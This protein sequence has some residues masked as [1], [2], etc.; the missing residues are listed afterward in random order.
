[1]NTPR[2]D[3]EIAQTVSSNQPSVCLFARYSA[4][5]A[6]TKS[7]AMYPAAEAAEDI[8][9]FSKMENSRRAREGNVRRSVENKAYARMHAVMLTPTFQ[10]TL[11]PTYKF[12]SDI[13]PPRTIPVTTALVVS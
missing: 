5:T 3:I 12:E 4:G 10:P 13:T 9:L 1:M 7:V 8:M 2:S 11:K 6:L